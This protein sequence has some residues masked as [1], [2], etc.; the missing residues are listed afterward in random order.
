MPRNPTRD[1][2]LSDDQIKLIIEGLEY[3]RLAQRGLQ[4]VDD[5]EILRQFVERERMAERLGSRLRRRLETRRRG[6]TGKYA[7]KL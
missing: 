2:I 5:P 1:V 3:V 7:E 6:S 4:G